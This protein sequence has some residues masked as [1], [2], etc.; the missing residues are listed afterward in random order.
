MAEVWGEFREEIVF[1]SAAS[2][3]ILTAV[4][5]IFSGFT[6]VRFFASKLFSEQPRIQHKPR[7]LDIKI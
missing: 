1:L 3:N 4:F 2:W 6:I 7:R 5:N